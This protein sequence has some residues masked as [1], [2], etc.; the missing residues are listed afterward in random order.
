VGRLARARARSR[1]RHVRLTT[2]RWWYWDI[3]EFG[4][5]PFET[6]RMVSASLILDGYPAPAREVKP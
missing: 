3:A 4:V 5:K 6:V 1:A 2:G